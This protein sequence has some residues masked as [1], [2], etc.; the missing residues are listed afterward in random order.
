MFPASPTSVKRHRQYY[1]QIVEEFCAEEEKRSRLT[2]EKRI[3][4]DGRVLLSGREYVR[5]KQVSKRSRPRK[6]ATKPAEF[7]S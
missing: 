4:E 1:L 7:D 2:L 5:G 6:T 3:A